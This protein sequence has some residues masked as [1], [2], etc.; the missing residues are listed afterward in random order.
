VIRLLRKAQAGGAVLRMA[1]AAFGRA[2]SEFPGENSYLPRGHANAVAM[3]AASGTGTGQREL[4]IERKG[5]HDLTTRQ[6]GQSRTPNH[7]EDDIF[8]RDF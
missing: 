8:V 5:S 7:A 2:D 6:S 1:V 3:T 4:D